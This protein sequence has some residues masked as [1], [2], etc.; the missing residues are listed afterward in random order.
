L[1]WR[2]Q[3]LLLLSG[4]VET[5]VATAA[6][7]GAHTA[8]DHCNSRIRQ[9]KFQGLALGTGVQECG[10]SLSNISMFGVSLWLLLLL[11]TSWAERLVSASKIQLLIYQLLQS[12][13]YET[14]YSSGILN[15]QPKP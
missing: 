8:L 14:P 3:L 15:L 5:L 12:T 10:N 6:S 1:R 11:L 4:W 9:M 7:Q 13:A 2:H